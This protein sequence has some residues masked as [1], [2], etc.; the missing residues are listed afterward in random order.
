MDNNVPSSL[1]DNLFQVI[2]KCLT[3]NDINIAIKT[4]DLFEI[5]QFMSFIK[6]NKIKFLLKIHLCQI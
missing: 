5:K 2:S 1:M 4:I 6:K 3:E